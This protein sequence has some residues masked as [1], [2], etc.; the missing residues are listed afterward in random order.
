MWQ[1][2][3]IH[4][5]VSVNINYVYACLFAEI[6][7]ESEF[8][9]DPKLYTG[10]AALTKML[11][12]ISTW[13]ELK[14]SVKTWCT[15]PAKP[16]GR[17]QGKKVRVL[18]SNEA[19]GSLMNTSVDAG[20][21]QHSDANVSDQIYSE[22]DNATASPAAITDEVAD[23]SLG[24][25]PP[26][27]QPK[28]VEIGKSNAASTSPG[29]IPDTEMVDHETAVSQ[30]AIADEVADQSMDHPPPSVQLQP[31]P[32]EI[33]N[34]DTLTNTTSTSHKAILIS[35]SMQGLD[36]GLLYIIKK[37]ESGQ[38]IGAENA[39]SLIAAGIN[40]TLP[41]SQSAANNFKGQSL[42]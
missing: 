7:N 4:K 23:H 18:R 31:P 35:S 3:F 15:P 37:A 39:L 30:S 11:E 28:Q 20:D 16:I 34:S 1:S 40:G 27:V 41:L 42:S 21:S 2:I 17:R 14:R 36:S 9:Y 32:V 24:H 6:L 10:D 25:P 19:G 5:I 33:G 13:E 26:S 8:R 38:F 22:T 29:A 12:K